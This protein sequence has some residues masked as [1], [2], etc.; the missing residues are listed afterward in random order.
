MP[1]KW[2]RLVTVQRPYHPH[3]CHSCGCSQTQ[4]HSC[5]AAELA[6]VSSHVSIALQRLHLLGFVCEHREALCEI[7]MPVT[8]HETWLPQ[9][10]CRL[11]C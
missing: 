4:L 2:H 10:P 3:C 8:W 5:R 7:V 1:V 9:G 6:H 11:Q